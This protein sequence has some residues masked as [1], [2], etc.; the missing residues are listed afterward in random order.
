MRKPLV[1][2]ASALCLAG[3]LL[4]TGCAAD[5]AG[6]ASSPAQPP[7]DRSS[8]PA[9]PDGRPGASTTGSGTPSTAPGSPGGSAPNLPASSSTTAGTGP[10][11]AA[12]HA[13]RA[14]LHAGYDQGAP[15]SG[16]PGLTA[17]NATAPDA[18][19][20]VRPGFRSRYGIMHKVVLGDD[21]YVSDG[22]PRSESATD[23][24]AAARFRVGD[25]RRYEFS[26]LL[27]DWQAYREGDPASVDILFQGKPTNS[28]P[29]SFFLAAKRNAI[30]FRDPGL[31]L[32][33]PVVADYRPYVGRWMRFRVDVRWA[34]DNT[35]SYRISTLLPGQ[36][37]FRLKQAYPRTK[38]WHPDNP[39]QYGY[40]KWGL[41]RPDSSLEN[42]SV[43]TRVV[44]HDDIR[45]SDPRGSS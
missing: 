35:G 11:G 32:Q 25:V 14:L 19:G 10:Q 9:V 44:H 38:T 31:D 15:D 28:N 42:G 40:V 21:G 37:A 45:I 8:R 13:P 20:P 33:S 5:V 1:T 27:K 4:A 23:K 12:H 6:A 3:S 36:S 29:P 7:Q 41:Y 24:V 39:A 2:L 18:A 34:D 16:I 43:R 22:A 17:T 26:V 30:V